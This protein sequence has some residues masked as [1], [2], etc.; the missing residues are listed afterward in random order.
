MTTRRALLRLAGL[1]AVAGAAYGGA[2]LLRWISE[3]GL[4]F[5]PVAGMPGFRRIA[6]GPVSGG[7]IALL[8]IDAQITPQTDD[9]M[10][11][12]GA[13]CAALFGPAPDPARIQIAYFTDYR[14][15]YCRKTSPMLAKMASGGDAQL[16]WHELPLLGQ[17]S[18]IA[19]RAAVAARAQGAYDTFHHRLMGT[20]VVPTPAYLGQL[21]DEA[22]IDPEK[23]LLDM[24]APETERQLRISAALARRFGFIGTPALVVGRTAVLGGVDRRLVERLI[25]AERNA[26]QPGIC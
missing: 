9:L 24:T 17:I 13:L 23:L 11:R 21:A 22:S 16:T 4:V 26:Q 25:A 3:P 12:D 1:T 10:I 14:C 6:D 18:S 20:P 8:G 7:A 15:M 5:E 19:A 2:A